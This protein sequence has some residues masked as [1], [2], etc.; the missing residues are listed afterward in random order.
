[1]R[2][3]ER[4]FMGEQRLGRKIGDKTG[5]FALVKRGKHGGFVDEFAP[6]KV[7]QPH[8]PFHHAEFIGVEH[9]T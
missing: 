6:R 5:C 8:T 7:D 1:M 9:A 3:T 4:L 2:R